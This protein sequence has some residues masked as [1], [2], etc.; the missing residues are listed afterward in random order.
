MLQRDFE[1]HTRDRWPVQNDVLRH[2]IE[3]DSPEYWMLACGDHGIGG[4][5]HVPGGPSNSTGAL[6]PHDFVYSR[7]VRFVPVLSFGPFVLVAPFAAQ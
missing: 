1:L 2:R 4:D 7:V 5:A 3:L 6:S